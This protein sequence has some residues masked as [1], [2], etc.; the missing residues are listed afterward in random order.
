MQPPAE[1]A[2]NQPPP[3]VDVNLFTTDPALSQAVER[4]CAGWANTRLA[5][6]GAAAGSEQFQ[7]WGFQANDY[8]P[9]LETHDRFGNRRDEVE[10]HPAWHELMSAAV[11]NLLHAL[12]WSDPRKGAQVARAA[13]MMIAG[14][15]EPGHLCPLS[16]TFSS[17]PVIRHH[18]GL[19]GEWEST[20]LSAAYDPRFQPAPRKMGA[21]VGMGMTEKQ[22][23]SDVR[24]N[25]TRAEPVFGDEYRID[26]HK[27]FCS[28]PMSDAFLILA[29][30]PGGLTCF[31]LPRWTPDGARNGFYIQR[32]KR[33]LGNRSNASSEVEFHD[34]WAR[35][36]GDEGRGVST[37]IEM[38]QHTR[39]DCSIGATALMRRALVEAVHHTRHRAAFG[40]L[41]SQQ[42]LMLSV[43]ADLALETE[44]AVAAVLRLARAFE[45]QPALARIATAA[46]KYWICKR[47]PA[48]VAESLECIGGSGYVEESMMPRLYREAP[49]NGIWEGSGNVIVLDFL[50][51]I[52]KD[53]ESLEALLAELR[54]ACGANKTYNA[55]LTRFEATVRNPIEE[56]GA[57]SILETAGLLFQAAELVRHAP[58]FVSDAFCAT[59]IGG[60]WGRTFGALPPAVDRDAIMKRAF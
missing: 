44:G 54:L 16:M 34:A 35:R 48:M 14:Q 53:P 33:K 59:R 9:V 55:A 24:A 41:L 60:E 7:R 43:I 31:F 25:I 38:V 45:D 39:L 18:A 4:N 23:G 28:A 46:V 13:L 2:L 49:L 10:F 26:G 56:G 40:R 21:L 6:F 47:A 17:V 22:G 29:Q 27:F 12:P 8:P 58:A 52:R 1:R 30:A 11:A 42:P 57:R 36:I 50:R 32:L 15:N 5:N 3:L 19:A 51:A 20:I 37:I